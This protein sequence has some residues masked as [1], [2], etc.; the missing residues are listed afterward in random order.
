[1]NDRRHLRSSTGQF[2]LRT[3]LFDFLLYFWTHSNIIGE[4]TLSLGLAPARHIWSRGGGQSH[5]QS[6]LCTGT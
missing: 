1:M 6:L 3:S 4:G 5:T 2:P